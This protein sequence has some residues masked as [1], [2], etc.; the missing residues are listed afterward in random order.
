M[1]AESRRGRLSRLAMRSRR[2]FRYRI[3][4]TDLPASVLLLAVSVPTT[5]VLAALAVLPAVVTVKEA[6]L[7]L[8]L[9]VEL[10]APPPPPTTVLISLKVVVPAL[11][12]LMRGV[13]AYRSSKELSLPLFTIAYVWSS[14]R[15]SEAS[16]LALDTNPVALV[17]RRIRQRIGAPNRVLQTRH[18]KLDREVLARLEQ[19]ERASV[20]GFKHKRCHIFA[21]WNLFDQP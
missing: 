6:V 13:P 15:L 16:W 1:E 7:S 8:E 4:E 3:A 17:T 14:V 2:S 19:R 20:A 11:V 18:C 21:L 9:T 10:R 5:A 12:M